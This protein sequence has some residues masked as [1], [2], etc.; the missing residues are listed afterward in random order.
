MDCR[1]IIHI[2]MDAFYASVE[3]RDNPAYRGKPIAVGGG[4]ERGVVAAASYEARKFGVHSAMSGKQAKKLCPDIIFAKTRFDDYRAISRQIRNIF[5]EYTPLVEPLSLDEAYLDVTHPLK[6]K[7]SATLIA[8]EIR[9]RIFAETSLT[10]SAGIS[11]NKFLAKIASDVNKPNGYFVIHPKD[12]AK[13]IEK[14]PIERFHGVGKVTAQKFKGLGIHNGHDLKNA[15]IPFIIKHF[16]K[17]GLFFYDIAHGNDKRSVEPDRERKSVGAENTYSSDL[18]DPEELNA[19]IREICDTLFERLQRAGVWGMTLTVKIKYHDFI[20]ITRSRTFTEAITQKDEM[21]QIS[22]EMLHEHREK[23]KPI[24][25][26][27]V[28]FS[29]LEFTGNRVGKQ[30]KIPF[31]DYPERV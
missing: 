3:Q 18:L 17:N 19:A 29:Q 27:G 23:D 15:E 31:R 22:C 28:T 26:L 13:F 25:L 7:N 30:L 12:A 20:Q 4:G 16:G 6:G 21:E 2:D 1:K 24:R 9:E 8:N 10:A 11:Y 5:L 14:L